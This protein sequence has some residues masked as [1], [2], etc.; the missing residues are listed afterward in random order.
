MMKKLILLLI[1][2]IIAINVTGCVTHSQESEKKK[3]GNGYIDR[4]N[5]AKDKSTIEELQQ[6]IV[7]V[8]EDEAYLSLTSS[9]K[10]AVANED[11][12]IDIADLI[13]TSTEVGQKAVNRISSIIELENNKIQ[14]KSDFNDECTIEIV[15]LNSSTKEVVVQFISESYDI[16]F[17]F[18]SM[19]EHDGIYSE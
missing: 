16:Q 14:L 18:D 19:G 3:L 6:I 2:S 7:Y 9:G 17:Y 4:T 11:G 5:L 10:P 15:K 1:A 13:D 8:L 12:Q